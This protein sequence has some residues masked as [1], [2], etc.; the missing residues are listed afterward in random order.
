MVRVLYVRGNQSQLERFGGRK[1]MHQV[2]LQEAGTQLAKLV[3]EA[4]NGEEVVITRSDGSAFRI[5]PI[6]SKKP[7]PT[8]GSAKGLIQNV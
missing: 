2:N 8:F 6:S 4:A 5:V 1:F 7:R 3:E